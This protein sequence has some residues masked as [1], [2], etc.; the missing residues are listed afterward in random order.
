MFS[1]SLLTS[2]AA[3]HN[4]SRR[5]SPGPAM[6]LHEM[7]IYSSSGQGWQEYPKKKEVK[8]LTLGGKQRRR[9]GKGSREALQWKSLLRRLRQAVKQGHLQPWLFQTEA[10][11]WRE[12][13]SLGPDPGCPQLSGHGTP[14]TVGVAGGGP[15]L[16]GLLA[17]RGSVYGVMI[18]PHAPPGSQPSCPADSFCKFHCKIWEQPGSSPHHHLT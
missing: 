10:I 17:S 11:P 16:R 8:R 1:S 4:P 15:A 5:P 3:P 7:E 2:S 12:R 9:S 13:G 14:M 6:L 18:N